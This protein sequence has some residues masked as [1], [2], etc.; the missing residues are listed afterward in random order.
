MPCHNHRQGGSRV[1]E[2]HTSAPQEYKAKVLD[3]Q[4]IRMEIG[5]VFSHPPSKHNLVSK[6]ATWFEAS[7]WSWYVMIHDVSWAPEDGPQQIFNDIYIFTYIY[8]L[9]YVWYWTYSYIVL[10]LEYSSWGS[11]VQLAQVQSSAW[12]FGNWSLWNCR[13]ISASFIQN[14]SEAY[15]PLERELVFDIDMD[16][17]D[18]IRTCCTGSKLCSKCWTFMKV[19]SAN[20]SMQQLCLRKTSC[21]WERHHVKHVIWWKRA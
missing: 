2:P 10:W 7:R 6:E 19:H 1:K 16:D 9:I 15:K 20:Q 11:D 12:V 5:A 18:D 17:Y 14:S 4:P 3:R 13:N 21:N 8:I